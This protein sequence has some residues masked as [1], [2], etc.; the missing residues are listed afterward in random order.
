[1]QV[2]DQFKEVQYV[3]RNTYGLSRRL[4]MAAFLLIA[5]F[6]S[7]L[8]ENLNGALL[9][10]GL[11]LIISCIVL[12]FVPSYTITL[13]D[14][15]LVIKPTY[16][17]EIRLPLDYI[18]KA[19]VVRYSRYHF[20]NVVFNVLDKDEYKFYAEGSKALLLNLKAGNIFRIGCKK[21]DELLLKI[22]EVRRDS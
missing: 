20:N 14:K 18:E 11:I 10:L 6:Y 22:G 8:D 13:T 3:G 15:I 2:A 4:V 5:H 7:P 17:K 1:M 19:E 21:A 9:Y 12:L 16:G